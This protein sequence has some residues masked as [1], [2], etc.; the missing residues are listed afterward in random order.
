MKKDQN[1]RPEINQD[2]M[3]A[4]YNTLL[5]DAGISCVRVGSISGFIRPTP[6]LNRFYVAEILINSLN[7]EELKA[8]VRALKADRKRIKAL[9]ARDAREEMPDKKILWR[10]QDAVLALICKLRGVK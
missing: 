8:L 9:Y 2:K 10:E 5:Y 4:I 1:D 3:S 6:P 7:D